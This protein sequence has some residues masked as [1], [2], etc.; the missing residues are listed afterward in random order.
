MMKNKNSNNDNT[1]LYTTLISIFVSFVIGPQSYETTFAN[2]YQQNL[3]SSFQNQNNKQ[4]I[5]IPYEGMK[6]I[7]SVE[8]YTLNS[9]SIHGKSNPKSGIFNPQKTSPSKSST[10]LESRT[11]PNSSGSSPNGSGGNNDGNLNYSLNPK[12]G[13]NI[14]TDGVN[15]Q[16][17]SKEKRNKIRKEQKKKNRKKEQEIVEGVNKEVYNE[18]LDQI[19]GLSPQKWNDLT[20]K[21][22]GKRDDEK[23]CTRKSI[24][25]GVIALRTQSDKV[26]DNVRSVDPNRF[27]DSSAD[28][29]GIDPETG[30]IMILEVK[31]LPSHE[32]LSDG[33]NRYYPGNVDKGTLTEMDQAA[34]QLGRNVIK[35]QENHYK[36]Y[37]DVKVVT[38]VDFEWTTENRQHL[39]TLVQA[40]IESAAKECGI[41]PQNVHFRGDE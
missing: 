33:D 35:Q 38:T 36:Q 6:T 21:L 24:Q 8:G 13:S 30:K 34:F 3:T 19:D 5:I 18:M 22:N 27:P 1:P 26:I 23:E 14:K 40:G 7:D 10:C 28:F 2:N 9:S 15:H 17:L 25:E 11:C 41:D 4:S 32:I 16:N 20:T 12:I 31:T 39:S 37:P 29:Q